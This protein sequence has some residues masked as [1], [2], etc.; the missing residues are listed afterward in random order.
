MLHPFG[1][2]TSTVSLHLRFEELI[3]I[4]LC[5][6][7][8]TDENRIVTARIKYKTGFFMVALFVD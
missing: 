4:C 6:K 1:V 8:G 5:A 3:T 2:N 7:D